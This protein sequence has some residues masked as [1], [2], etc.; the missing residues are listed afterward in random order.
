MD[1]RLL[2]NQVARKLGEAPV[3]LAPRR[4]PETETER[5]SEEFAPSFQRRGGF[6]AGQAEGK[7]Q[8]NEREKSHCP[9]AP[10]GRDLGRV[11]AS[12]G[13]LRAEAAAHAGLGV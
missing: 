1:W 12:S 2:S 8:G 9:H 7:P 5:A 4:A 3:A 11:E 6:R 13:Q 10:P